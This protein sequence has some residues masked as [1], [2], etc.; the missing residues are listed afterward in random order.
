MSLENAKAFL[1]K[2][3]SDDNFRKE[4]GEKASPEER[5]QFIKN[6]GFDFTKDELDSLK[7]E[8][9]DEELDLVAGGGSW[10]GHCGY[11]H[12]GETLDPAIIKSTASVVDVGGDD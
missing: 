10:G 3:K 9:S 12:E 1:E 4:V 6:A 11:T 2:I 5:V 8:L 7:A